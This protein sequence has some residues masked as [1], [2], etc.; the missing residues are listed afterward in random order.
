MSCVKRRGAYVAALLYAKRPYESATT[1]VAGRNG[2]RRRA[3][4]FGIVVLAAWAAIAGLV[5]IEALPGIP[6]SIESSSV[7]KTVGRVSWAI[8]GL[9]LIVVG[10]VVIGRREAI[11]DEY[12]R[13]L[14]ACTPVPRGLHV[15]SAITGGVYLVWTGIGMLI[16]A[17]GQ[18][19]STSFD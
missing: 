12:A 6:P 14:K 8:M 10:A 11:I 9:A 7:F 2:A 5:A 19:G 4:V 15:F 3:F 1:A 13:H 18:G 17:M 16:H